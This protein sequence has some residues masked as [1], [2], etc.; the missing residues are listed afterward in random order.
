MISACCSLTQ[1]QTALYDAADA[2]LIEQHKWQAWWNS[3]TKSFYARRMYWDKTAKTYRTEFM[4]RLIMGLERG[5]ERQVDHINHNTLDNRR[6]NL[7]IVTNKQNNQNRRNVKGYT[8]DKF[9]KRWKARIV[10]D[11]KPIHL[12]QFTTEHEAHQ[13][14]L[15]ARKVY[16]FINE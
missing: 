9:N 3:K 1:G 4:A 12:G 7:R 10:V 15:D 13:A 5:D 16:N 2:H 8:W 11:G 6:Q 14:Y